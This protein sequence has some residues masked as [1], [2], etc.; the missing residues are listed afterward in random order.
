[1]RKNVKTINISDIKK[2]NSTHISPLEIANKPNVIN[3][4]EIALREFVRKIKLID[5]KKID[6]TITFFKVLFLVAK[7]H[8]MQK[9]TMMFNQ[10]P[11]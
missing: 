5:A 6:D 4:L 10:H 3:K 9:G 1:M 7:K 8:A 11:L 2:R